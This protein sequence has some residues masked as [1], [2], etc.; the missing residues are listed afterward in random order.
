VRGALDVLGR[1]FVLHEGSGVRE[2]GSR[3]AALG[4]F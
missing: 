4:R 2:V 1:V 3:G